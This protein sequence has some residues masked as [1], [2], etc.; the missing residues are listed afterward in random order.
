MIPQRAD[1]QVLRNTCQHLITGIVCAFTE[2]RPLTFRFT[3]NFSKWIEWV[4]HCGVSQ[5]VASSSCPLGLTSL[6]LTLRQ[7]VPDCP[8]FDA[9]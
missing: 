3:D 5:S 4:E 1:R 8:G 2:A 9:T 6:P 7:P